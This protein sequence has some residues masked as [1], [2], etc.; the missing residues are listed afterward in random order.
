M[1]G[2]TCGLKNTAAAITH[3]FN[4]TGVK[5]GVLKLENVLS[6]PAASATKEMK[7]KYGNVMRSIVVVSAILFAS[8]EKPAAIA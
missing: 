5:A 2:S 8:A 7:N 6:I 1:G 3:K 4:N